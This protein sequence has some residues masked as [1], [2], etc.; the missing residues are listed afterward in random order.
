[1]DDDPPDAIP[2]P[3]PSPAGRQVLRTDPGQDQGGILR[4]KKRQ[5]PKQQRSFFASPSPLQPI[6]NESLTPNKGHP[7][8]ARNASPR[9]DPKS[10]P[11]IESPRNPLLAAPS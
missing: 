11:R 1:M 5:S 7:Q 2:S 10:D 3:S 9:R 4:E 6:H 8:S